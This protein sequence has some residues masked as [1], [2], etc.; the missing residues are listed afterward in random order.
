MEYLT[1][2]YHYLMQNVPASWQ[3]GIMALLI[4]IFFLVLGKFIS[5][6]IIS[7]V[8]KLVS[9]DSTNLNNRIIQSFQKPLRYLIIILGTYWALLYLPLTPVHDIFVGKLFRCAIIIMLAWGFYELAGTHSTISDEI[10]SR[11]KLDDILLPFFS[12]AIRFVIIALAIVLCA[13]EWDYDINGFI[14][15]LGLGGLAFALAAKDALANIFGGIVIIME[16]PFS[17]GDWVTTPSV[18]GTVEDISFRSTRFRTFAQA[19]V[20]VPNSTLAN[21]AITNWSRMGKRRVS[22]YLGLNYL[23]SPDK[24]EIAVD[25]I[26][27]LLKSESTIHGDNV[28]VSFENFQESSLDILVQYFTRTTVWA[29]NLKVKEEI[30]LKIMRLLQTEG[31][32]MAFPSRSIYIENGEST[33]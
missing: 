8:L 30:N 11:F 5:T 1:T 6:T 16:K 24:I 10:K 26:T 29:E 7:A 25:K 12:K 21:E 27:Q 28:L 13:S 4:F 32:S 14:T 2:S 19:L 22:F 15:G 20:T 9:R 23:T 31:I 33:N 17:I 3:A 18:E